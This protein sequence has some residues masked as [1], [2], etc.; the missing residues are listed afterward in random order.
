[1]VSRSVSRF[2][3][4]RE[5][6]ASGASVV[7]IVLRNQFVSP[8]RSSGKRPISPSRPVVLADERTRQKAQDQGPLVNGKPT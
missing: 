1:M 6:L 8:V 4:T 5:K 3:Q 7:V 2:A